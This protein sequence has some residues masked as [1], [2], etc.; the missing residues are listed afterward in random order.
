MMGQSISA[1]F[2]LTSENS[3][4]VPK[5]DKAVCQTRGEIPEQEKD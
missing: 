4:P 2:I 5:I 3:D 1:A